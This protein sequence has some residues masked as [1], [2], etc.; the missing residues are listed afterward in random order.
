VFKAN[1][2]LGGMTPLA[3]MLEKEVSGIEM[4][5]ELAESRG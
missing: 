4:I 5:K 1:D 2:N 3:V